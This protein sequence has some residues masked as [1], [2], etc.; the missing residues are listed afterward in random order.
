MYQIGRVCMKLAGRDAGKIC[1][2]VSLDK[3]GRVLIDGETRRRLC[4]II[5]LE[6]LDSVVKIKSGASNA[7]VVKALHALGTYTLKEKAASKTS[8]S[9]KAPLA[10]RPTKL[11]SSKKD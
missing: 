2:I 6:P 5:H 7:D 1:V 10:K 9:P 3:N 4:N 11:K 8:T